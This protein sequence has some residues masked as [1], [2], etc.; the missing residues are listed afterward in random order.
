MA[1]FEK[2]VRAETIGYDT[3]APYESRV[4]RERHYSVIA[5]DASGAVHRDSFVAGYSTY[6][7]LQRLAGKL[8]IE[9]RGIERVPDDERTDKNTIKVGTMVRTALSGNELEHCSLTGTASGWQ[10][11]W[12]YPLSQSAFSQC[13]SSH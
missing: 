10:R 11:T 13:P 12:W 6:A 3:E 1:S 2:S 4:P 7:K 9:Q 5:P 8:Q